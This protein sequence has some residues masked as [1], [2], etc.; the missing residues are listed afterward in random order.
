MNA[1]KP[2]L[3][4]N[5]KIITC[6]ADAL[7]A[8]AIALSGKKIAAVGHA[9]QLADDYPNARLIDAGGRAVMPG[10]IDGHSH[11]DSGTP[12]AWASS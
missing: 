2:L 9:E 12:A 1:E 7:I 6:D 8:D 3:I 5:A 10:M 4:R 11:M